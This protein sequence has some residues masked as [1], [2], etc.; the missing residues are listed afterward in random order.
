MT[1][2]DIQFLNS[3]GGHSIHLTKRTPQQEQRK[4][5]FHKIKASPAYQSL[6]KPN[7]IDP[8]TT[9]LGARNNELYVIGKCG[10]Q[11]KWIQISQTESPLYPSLHFILFGGDLP[12]EEEQISQATS[13]ASSVASSEIP[14]SSNADQHKGLEEKPTASSQEIPMHTPHERAS[15]SHQFR[16]LRPL[17][18]TAQKLVE[19]VQNKLPSPSDTLILALISLTAAEK[20]IDCAT[21]AAVNVGSSVVT[22]GK[23]TMRESQFVKRV[24]QN[25]PTSSDVLRVLARGSVTIARTMLHFASTLALGAGSL[26]LAGLRNAISSNQR[27]SE[28]N[29]MLPQDA[30]PMSYENEDYDLS[31]EDLSSEPQTPSTQREESDFQRSFF[32]LAPSHLDAPSEDDDSSL[33][34]DELF[35]SDPSDYFPPDD[36]SLKQPATPSTHGEPDTQKSFFNLA[37]P[38]LEYA[39][40]ECDDSGYLNPDSA[41][42]TPRLERESASTK[43]AQSSFSFFLE[44]LLPKSGP[45]LQASEPAGVEETEASPAPPTGLARLWSLLRAAQI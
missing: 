19:S 13:E 45:K 22:A 6:L 8:Q 39:P 10:G 38:H 9:S 7:D 43:N 20:V 12:V 17:A 14:L 40:S 24:S 34:G 3:S 21:D 29:R 4:A 26:V 23:K 31:D 16:K 44:N 18:T 37:R 27:N 42:A 1:A 35:T 15:F 32:N 33:S 28:V 5:L 36:D 2:L 11:R 30:T 41:Q 25:L